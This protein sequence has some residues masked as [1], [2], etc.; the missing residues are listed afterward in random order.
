[1][2]F[3]LTLVS[4]YVAAAH[5]SIAAAVSRQAVTDRP[6]NGP[7][8]ARPRGKAADLQARIRSQISAANMHDMEA[9]LTSFLAAQYIC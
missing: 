4:R 2:S 6:A 7:A 5:S 1:V 9:A 3:A 8:S